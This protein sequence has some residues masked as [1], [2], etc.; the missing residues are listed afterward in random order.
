MILK[1][2]QGNKSYSREESKLTSFQV[3]QSQLPGKLLVVMV[4][5]AF[6]IILVDFMDLEIIR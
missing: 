5:I 3:N 4:A 2:Y 1:E 6:T